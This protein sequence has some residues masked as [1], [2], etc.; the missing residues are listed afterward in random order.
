MTRILTLLCILFAG[1]NA[2]WADKYQRI[3]STSDLVV[4]EK[5]LIVCETSSKAMGEIGKFGGNTSYG[6]NVSVVIADDHTFTSQST[7]LNVLSLNWVEN[8]VVGDSWAITASKNND[9]TLVWTTGNSLSAQESTTYGKLWTIAFDNNGNAIIANRANK[10]RVIRFNSASNS[11]RFACYEGTQKAV[12][13][14]KLIA[15]TPEVTEAG[16]ATYVPQHNVEFEKGV[17][18]VAKVSG[19][20]VQLT[21]VNA[22]KAGTPVLLKVEGSKVATITDTTPDDVD[23]DLL[24]SDGT[25]VGDETTIYVLANKNDKVGFYLLASGVTLPEGKAY[26]S[27]ANGGAHEFLGFGDATAVMPI[28]QPQ[29]TGK[30]AYYD[31]QGRRVAQPTK[32][33]YLK[34]GRKVI[35]K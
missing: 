19:N 34:D 28:A 11:M 1:S 14:Y 15:E 5:Y 27:V 25:V 3:T 26:L 30:A 31:L 33:L 6:K 22:V 13:L 2:L 7:L 16:W 17:A 9:K 23:T 18:F 20:M 24:V 32:G 21:D 4:G 12:Q 8:D 10:D 29:A 35:V